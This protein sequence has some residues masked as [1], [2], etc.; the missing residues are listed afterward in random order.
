[1]VIYTFNPRTQEAEANRGL[2][3]RPTSDY[4]ISSRTARLHRETLVSEENK[5]R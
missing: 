3:L 1:M 5:T 4:I 2:S